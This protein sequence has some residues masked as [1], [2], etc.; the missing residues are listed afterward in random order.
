VKHRR[1]Q[2]LSGVWRSIGANAGRVSLALAASWVAFIVLLLIPMA[3]PDEPVIARYEAGVGIAKSSVEPLPIGGLADSWSECIEILMHFGQDRFLAVARSD[4]PEVSSV[5]CVQYA[6]AAATKTLDDQIAKPTSYTRYWH[7][8]SVVL[9]PI[10]AYIGMDALRVLVGGLVLIAVGLWIAATTK[11]ANLLVAV[12]LVAPPALMS[13]TGWLGFS[14]QH[15]LAYAVVIASAAV[16]TAIASSRS[17]TATR[18]LWASVA[19]AGA[20]ANFVDILNVAP[21][22]WAIAAA[23][24][25][26]GLLRRSEAAAK[27]ALGAGEGVGPTS[28]V[29][30][31]LTGSFIAALVWAFAFGLTWV[32]RWLLAI[33]FL[34]VRAVFDD[35]TG[36]VAIRGGVAERLWTDGWTVTLAWWE[37]LPFGGWRPALVVLAV[38]GLVLLVR[39]VIARGRRWALLARVGVSAWAAVLVPIWFLA[40]GRHAADHGWFMYRGWAYALGIVAAAAFIPLPNGGWARGRRPLEEN[41][42][43]TPRLPLA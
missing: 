20:L 18:W 6:D 12:A 38:A 24:V 41:L 15:A 22:A 36:A 30:R 4:Y 42:G 11:A 28:G 29:A 10:F 43:D 7:G 32:V 8:Y 39:L 1:R 31:I 35:V 19:I 34:G 9:R 23:G 21:V 3:V 27:P 40:L 25:A 5:P 2:G 17:L 26:I 14:V 37:R 16:L 13:D 33:P